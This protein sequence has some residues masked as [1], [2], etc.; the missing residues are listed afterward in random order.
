[1]LGERS[2]PLWLERRRNLLNFADI[3]CID[4][5]SHCISVLIP[6][7]LQTFLSDCCSRSG[8]VPLCAKRGE[9]MYFGFQVSDLSSSKHW[10]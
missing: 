4:A 8:D 2:L 3:D 5:Q 9:K 7:R 1:M 10:S 6:A